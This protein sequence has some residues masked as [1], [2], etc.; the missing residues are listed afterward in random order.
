MCNAGAGPEQECM[1]QGKPVEYPVSAG[2]V[3]YK[4]SNGSIEFVLCGRTLSQT[5]SLPNGTPELG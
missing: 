2:G 5:W 4:T 3:V 1:A